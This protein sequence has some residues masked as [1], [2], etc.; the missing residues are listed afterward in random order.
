MVRLAWPDGHS[1][2][3][4]DIADQTGHGPLTSGFQDQDHLGESQDGIKTPRTRARARLSMCELASVLRTRPPVGEE[5]GDAD[6]ADTD[7]DA[8]K[9]PRPPFHTQ[10][11]PTDRSVSVSVSDLSGLVSAVS[12]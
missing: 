9:V 5:V 8:V 1:T 4:H 2:G 6:A 7:A 12:Y 10:V 11:L 3:R